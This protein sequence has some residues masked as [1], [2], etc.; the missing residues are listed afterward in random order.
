MPRFDAEK[1]VNRF[2]EATGQNFTKVYPDIIAAEKVISLLRHE[3]DIEKNRH[4]K[5][6]FNIQILE[7]RLIGQIRL[8]TELKK[9]YGVK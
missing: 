5:N 7:G 1:I 4:I 8:M 9:K 2:A 3:L 6:N